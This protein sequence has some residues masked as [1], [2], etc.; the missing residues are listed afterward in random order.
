M[1]DMIIAEKGGQFNDLLKKILKND[2]II[3]DELGV[4]PDRV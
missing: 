4:R 2:L 1:E 3:I